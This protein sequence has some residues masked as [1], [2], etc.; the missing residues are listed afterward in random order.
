MRSLRKQHRLVIHSEGSICGTGLL[1]PLLL[2]FCPHLL[3][4]S[5]SPFQLQ[6]HW[7]PSVLWYAL[8][9]R[10]LQKWSWMFTLGYLDNEL[11]GTT[12]VLAGG[13]VPKLSSTRGWWLPSPGKRGYKFSWNSRSPNNFYKHLA[14][15]IPPAWLQAM[16]ITPLRRSLSQ[17]VRSFHWSTNPLC[18]Q[19]QHTSLWDEKRVGS[20]V[21]LLIPLISHL[22]DSPIKPVPYAFCGML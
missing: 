2:P 9:S 7:P 8:L 18:V 17:R 22:H 19:P 13:V 5:P 3:L 6:N 10:N 12:L 21:P 11:I 4:L 14:P 16:F 20:W 15:Q 1:P